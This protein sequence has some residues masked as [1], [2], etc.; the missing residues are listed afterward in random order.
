MTTTAQDRPHSISI[1]FPDIS[2]YTMRQFLQRHGYEER[3]SNY[4]TK[5]H[6]YW[7][8][9]GVEWVHMRI[10]FA[11]KQAATKALKAVIFERGNP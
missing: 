3:K 5:G 1:H 4:P 2:E 7:I 8:V 11:F 6:K 9:K 10:D